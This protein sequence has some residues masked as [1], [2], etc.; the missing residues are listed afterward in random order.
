MNL[1][2]Q[3]HLPPVPL[4]QTIKKYKSSIGNDQNYAFVR[5]GSNDKMDAV[6]ST[7][8]IPISMDW[9]PMFVDC[10]NFGTAFRQLVDLFDWIEKNNQDRLM[11]LLGMVALACCGTDTLSMAISTLS[12][13]WTQLKYHATTRKWAEEAWL[14][15][16]HEMLEEDSQS[17]ISS[18]PAPWS[19]SK[20]ISFMPGQDA[21]Q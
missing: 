13:R 14:V 7:W 9:A 8:M 12:T 5:G 15:H 11:P 3:V 20:M 18:S 4:L 1:F 10:S 6:A 2:V 16:L 17:L 19:R 21:R